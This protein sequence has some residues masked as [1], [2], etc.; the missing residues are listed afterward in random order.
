MRR[1]LYVQFTDPAGYPPVEHSSV[2]LVKRGWDVVLLG[3]VGQ[4]TG[5]ELPVVPGLLVRR[6]RVFRGGWRQKLQYILFV[7]WVFYWTW[8]WRP[9][10]I[11]ASDPLSCPVVWWVRKFTGVR[12]IYHEHDTPHLDQAY[13]WFMKWVFAYRGALARNA[14]LCVLPQFARLG[15]FV[16]TTGR[17]KP[18]YCVWNCPRLDEVVSSNPEEGRDKSIQDQRLIIYYHGSITP[19]RLPR[20]LTAAATQFKGSVKLQLI[21]YETLGSIGYTR[22]LIGLASESKVAGIIEALGT[23][24]LRKH[25]F[26]TASKADVGLALMPKRSE[27][28]NMQHMVGASNKPFDYMACGLPLLVTDLPEWVETFVKPGYA[29]ACDPDDP[30]LIEAALRWYLEHPDERREMGRR[31][32]DKIRQSWNYEFMFADVIKTIENG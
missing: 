23:I 5:L 16:E 1:I 13:T 27:D 28:L 4:A 30:E 19:A 32:R 18:C 3:V 29:L 15:H 24:P 21:G 17:M 7:L 31:G 10:W 2:L 25:V 8:R 12:V 26:R 9:Q 11:Y 20:Q 6:M 14:E 22:E